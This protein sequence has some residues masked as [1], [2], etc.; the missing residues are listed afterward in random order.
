[1]IEIADALNSLAPNS[2]WFYEKN[3]YETLEW[4]SSEF[5][6]PTFEEVQK[7]II[8]LQKI[9]DA[10]TYQSSRAAEYPDFRDYLDGIVKGDN[11]QVQ[12]YIDKC[13]AVKAKYP[14]PGE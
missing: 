12:E 11:A 6:K 5:P 9:Q 14:K 7:E 13:L 4:R 10:L 2:E 3:D 8:R 1:M